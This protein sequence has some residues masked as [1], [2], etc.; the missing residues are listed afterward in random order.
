MKNTILPNNSFQKFSDPLGFTLIEMLIVIAII[1]ILAAIVYLLIN[2][3]ELMKRS[4]DAVRKSDMASLARA[5]DIYMSDGF[6]SKTFTLPGYN[7]VAINRDSTETN[8]CGTSVKDAVH[9]GW[10]VADTATLCD[11]NGE[12]DLSNYISNLPLDPLNNS[13]Y[14]YSY[15]SINGQ[16]YCLQAVLEETSSFWQIGTDVLNCAN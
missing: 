6:G 1:A 7:N 4:R 8:V 15:D 14:K 16:K 10:L 2:P 13:T 3:V 12:A 11:E 9:G 5:I